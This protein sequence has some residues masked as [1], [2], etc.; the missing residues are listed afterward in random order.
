MAAARDRDP[1]A[2]TVGTREIL[3]TYPGVH[4]ILAHRISHA[5]HSAEVPLLPRLLSNASRIVTG[6]EIH[7]GRADRRGLLRRPRHRR[8]DRRDGRDR[9]PRH[10]APGR[11][12]RRHRLR[13]GQAAPDASR[14]TSPSARARSCSGPITVGHGAKVGANSVVIHDV[15]PNT[16]VVGNPGPPGARRGPQAR[17][18]GHRLAAPARPGR[19]RAAR[20]GRAHRPSSSALVAELTGSEHK[21]PA[22]GPPAAPGPGPEPGR[23]V[24]HR[25][26]VRSARGE[27]RDR[28]ARG[29]AARPAP[30]SCSRT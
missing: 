9:R 15:P 20:A 11:H 30:S 3:L 23:R 28:R 7:P 19:G 4:A 26:A 6:I 16:T 18:P 14:T 21:E 25:H 22:R 8:R 17:G 24:G 1:A 13:R 29:R 2:R 10:A 12:A 27:E 5:L